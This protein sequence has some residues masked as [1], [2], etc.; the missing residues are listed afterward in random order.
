[1]PGNSLGAR[2]WYKYTAD[3]GTIYSYLTDVDLGVAAGAV[4]DASYPNLPRRFKPRVV[5]CEGLNAAGKKIRKNVIV[6]EPDNTLYVLQTTQVALIDAQ[7][8]KTTGRRGEHV[9]FPSNAL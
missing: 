3:S 8:F 5:F 7:A 6:P 2:K 9:S 4:E 1:M